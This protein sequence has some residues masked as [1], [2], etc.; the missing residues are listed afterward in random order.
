MQNQ[1]PPV[2]SKLYG[3]PFFQSVA[4]RYITLLAAFSVGTILS[5]L[6]LPHAL[7]LSEVFN[8]SVY[9]LALTSIGC[10][11]AMS[12]NL[13][14][15]ATLNNF[16]AS[17]GLPEIVTGGIVSV[18]FS[19]TILI[20]QFVAPQAILIACVTTFSILSSALTYTLVDRLAFA[21][22]TIPKAYDYARGKIL[23][24]IAVAT[25]A[26]LFFYFMSITGASIFP[27]IYHIGIAS[28]FS[29]SLLYDLHTVIFD[30]KI[31]L[32]SGREINVEN[33]NPAFCALY[34]FARTVDVFI[35]IVRVCIHASDLNNKDSK[36]QNKA[37]KEIINTIV[38]T[39]FIVGG[40]YI[41]SA[42]FEGQLFRTRLESTDESRQPSAPPV[43]N[44]P[45]P[46][47]TPAEQVLQ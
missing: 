20:S 30:Q 5:L 7:I 19:K 28:W 16:Y 12:R 47:Y 40:F 45:P 24:A 17:G 8:F 1:E 26:A 11:V 15:D 25:A 33:D 18:L 13:L 4:I 37:W 38:G 6:V 27:F 46:A 42:A 43:Y 14:G 32:Y 44:G 35:A 22:N 10:Y 23:T 31:V 34:L 3:K 9:L 41:I 36:K 2:Y 39:A 29:L 21:S